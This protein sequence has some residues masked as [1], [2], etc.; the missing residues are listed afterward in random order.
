MPI[1][2]SEGEG[3]YPNYLTLSL[4]GDIDLGEH[5]FALGLYKRIPD[6]RHNGKPVWK[7]VVSDHYLFF[8]GVYEGN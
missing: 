7:Y 8:S 3:Q 1:I 6:L 4:D 5:S 2:F